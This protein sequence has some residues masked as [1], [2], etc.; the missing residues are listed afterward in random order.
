MS[1][2]STESLRDKTLLFVLIAHKDVGKCDLL[3][4]CCIPFVQT[5]RRVIELDVDRDV[6]RPAGVKVADDFSRFVRV[7]TFLEFALGEAIL[8]E[9][10]GKSSLELFV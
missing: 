7:E 6:F 9:V 10:A 8:L 1:S 5:A 3:R 2:V 4:L